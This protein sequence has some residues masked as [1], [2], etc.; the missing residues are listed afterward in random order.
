MKAITCILTAVAI[1]ISLLAQGQSGTLDYTFGDE[2]I[3]LQSV[4]GAEQSTDIHILND[5]KILTL[6]NKLTNGYMSDIILMRH[7]TDG[8]LDNTFGMD[9]FSMISVPNGDV[10]G[11]HMKI[12]DESIYIG[13]GIFD[14]NSNHY[15]FLAVKCNLTDGSLDDSFGGTGYVITDPDPTTFNLGYGI[16]VQ[17][18]GKVLVAGKVFENI[19]FVRHNADG[20]LDNTFGNNGIVICDFVENTANF[21]YD[22]DV[23]PDGKILASGYSDDTP[24]VVRLNTDGTFDPTFG[25]DGKALLVD[26]NGWIFDHEIQLDGKILIAGNTLDQVAMVCRLNSDGSIDNTFGTAGA[27]ILPTQPDYLG[28]WLYAVTVQADG[29]PLLGGFLSPTTTYITDNLLARLTVDGQLD[30]TFGDNGI[31]TIIN[32]GSDV[33][34]TRAIAV[35]ADEKIVCVGNNMVSSEYKEILI[36]RFHGDLET[37]NPD[38]SQQNTQ[39]LIYPNP[40]ND[41]LNIISHGNWNYNQIEIVDL[42]GQTV[43]SKNSNL[44]KATIDVSWLSNGVYFLKLYSDNKIEIQKLIKQ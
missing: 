38:W 19:G 8:T 28:S 37:G 25:I 43:Y 20:S 42:A 32:L 17:D 39:V 41:Q 9:G 30:E 2:G 16:G 31:A 27:F 22:I 35:Q 26:H 24:A 44:H 5:G 23:L 18:D 6:A 36:A 21:C 7:N 40:V 13:G 34:E 11:E 15:N 12:V 33:E 3:T 29:K 4:T 10:W 1:F 14:I